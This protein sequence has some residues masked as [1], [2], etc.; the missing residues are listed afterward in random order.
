MDSSSKRKLLK[1]KRDSGYKSQSA[2]TH[3][4][5]PIPP[6]N[7]SSPD[8][9]LKENSDHRLN[10]RRDFASKRARSF[11]APRPKYDT[12]EVPRG[13]ENWRPGGNLSPPHSS[14]YRSQVSPDF[15]LDSAR[16]MP[17]KGSYDPEFI[18]DRRSDAVFREFERYDPRFEVKRAA[19]NRR[20]NYLA[21]QHYRHTF[22]YAANYHESPQPQS[23]R[24]N[25]SNAYGAYRGDPSAAYIG[26]SRPAPS[27]VT[28]QGH[29]Y[30][31]NIP[32]IK[33]PTGEVPTF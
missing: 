27:R 12:V 33:L 15:F 8:V 21:A 32:L 14:S 29:I 17:R 10:V 20:Q 6:K 31:G 19:R 5:L 13:V 7:I 9:H 16:V 11:E 26:G 23:Q 30:S 25:N 3:P 1:L 18:I 24:I 4:N 2:E 22:D 28:R